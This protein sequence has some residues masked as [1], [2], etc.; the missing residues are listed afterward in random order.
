[1]AASFET[2]G[3]SVETIDSASMYC[4]G[5]NWVR[6]ASRFS[7]GRLL[8]SVRTLVSLASRIGITFTA[9]LGVR[10]VVKPFTCSTDSNTA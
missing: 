4:R 9:P 6:Y 2:N 8:E 5:I 3:C 1:M 7:G 10:T